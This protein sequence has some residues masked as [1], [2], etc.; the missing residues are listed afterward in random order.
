MSDYDVIVVGA[1]M[2]GASLSANLAANRQ[3]VLMLESEDQPGYHST[4]RSAALWHE[5]YGGAGVQP[6]TTAS[7]PFLAD[8][9]QDF[10][11]GS[12]L[13]ERGALNIASPDQHDL[14]TALDDEFAGTGIAMERVGR[15]AMEE[16]V[17][18][19]LDGWS[20]AIWEPDCADIDVGALHGAYLR[21]CRREG[22]EI[23]TRAPLERARW[24]DG[25]WQVESPAGNWTAPL[26]VDAAGAWAD[27]VAR[28]CG[29]ESIGIRPYRRTMVQLRVEP[30]APPELP[31]V[32]GID[33][34]FY[35]RP[36][37]GGRLWLSPHDEIPTE[38]CDAA[39]EEIDVAIAI[40]RMQSVVDW[41]IA[42]VERKWAGLRS[43]AP[44]RLPVIGHDPAVPAFFWFA[45]QGGFGIQTAPA[46]AWLADAA[47]REAGRPDAVAHVDAARYRPDRFR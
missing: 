43:F 38:P 7:G 39:P 6:L 8:P 14:L 44:D 25:V 28:R 34:S 46:A 23:A 13:T 27:E 30:P 47:I 22:A 35:F 36:E 12:F 29:V 37:S 2:A 16:H 32:R 15:S 4:G 18:G 5:S 11:E 40:D 20:E 1:G 19:L 26:L 9:P 10:H 21:K 17:P 41:R 42:A 45:G 33:G 24:Q 3:R 31:L